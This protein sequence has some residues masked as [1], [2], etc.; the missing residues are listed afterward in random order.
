M[1]DLPTVAESGVA[2][3]DV[4][5]WNGILAP[6]GT[7]QAIVARLN[8]ELNKIVTAPEMRSRLIEFGYELL[9]GRPYN[10]GRTFVRKS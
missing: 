5:Y 8:N 4:T 6:T 2:G 9:V 1:P 7:P 3:Y 10:S